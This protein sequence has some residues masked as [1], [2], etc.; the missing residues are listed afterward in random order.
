LL[1]VPPRVAVVA[2]ENKLSFKLSFW[3]ENLQEMPKMGFNV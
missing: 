2:L 1:K 3:P